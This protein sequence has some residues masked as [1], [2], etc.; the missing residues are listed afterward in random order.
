[1]KC[2]QSIKL[3]KNTEIGT[4]KRI[5]DVE[6]DSMVKSGYWEYISKS[7]YKKNNTVQSTKD[8]KNIDLPTIG[9]KSKKRNQNK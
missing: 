6:A 3:T 4:R 7:E 5:N 8:I 2:I 1:M 9:I